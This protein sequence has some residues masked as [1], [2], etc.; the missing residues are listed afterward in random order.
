MHIAIGLYIPSS[1][2]QTTL[3]L[4]LCTGA[5]T[6]LDPQSGLYDTKMKPSF[7]KPALVTA[8][9]PRAWSMDETSQVLLIQGRDR[10][11]LKCYRK[12]ISSI[13][14]SPCV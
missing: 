7:T 4:R 2:D 6:R 5:L 10:T 14:S 9:L 11:F 8:W 13:F 1:I 12:R 3:Y